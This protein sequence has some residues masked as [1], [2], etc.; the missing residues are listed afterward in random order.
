MEGMFRIH[1]CD[2]VLELVTIVVHSRDPCKCRFIAWVGAHSNHLAVDH[3][4][5][6]C[7]GGGRESFTEAY[8]SVATFQS[9]AIGS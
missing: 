5:F 6:S 3:D 2:Q 7:F 4:T 9:F 8:N 1:E